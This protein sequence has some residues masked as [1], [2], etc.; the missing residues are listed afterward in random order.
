[1]IVG[2]Q[3]GYRASWET[4]VGQVTEQIFHDNV[5]AWSG[6]HCIDHSLVPGV[7]FCNH[8]IKDEEPRLMDI[9]PTV[10]NLFGVEVP[11][12]MDGRQLTVL[13]GKRA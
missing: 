7:L 1:L 6:D 4:A 3:A 2:Y 8:E 5:K 11:A 9:G 10:L 12:H 13:D